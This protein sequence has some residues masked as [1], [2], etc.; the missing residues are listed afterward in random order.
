VAL[1]L[2]LVACS[3]EEFRTIPVGGSA[4]MA[5][6]VGDETILSDLDATQ[7]Q[8]VCDEVRRLVLDRVEQTALKA[9]SCIRIAW[10]DEQAGTTTCETSFEACMA[11]PLA[12]FYEFP[13]NQLFEFTDQCTSVGSLRECHFAYGQVAA[14]NVEDALQAGVTSCGEARAAGGPGEALMP[15][16]TRVPEPC[17]VACQNACG[18]CN[19]GSE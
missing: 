3:G 16:A 4:G 6:S 17:V 8:T 1:V 9:N 13:C 15:V 19:I 12:Q 14:M 10:N 18:G 5:G 11:R 2:L 7:R